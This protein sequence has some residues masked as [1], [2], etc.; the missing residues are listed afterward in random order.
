MSH[1]FHIKKKSIFI[2]IVLVNFFFN[3]GASNVQDSIRDMPQQAQRTSACVTRDSLR[4][5]QFSRF[6]PENSLNLHTQ[7]LGNQ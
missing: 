6:T 4:K 1:Y 7:S 2:S 3:Y 5:L